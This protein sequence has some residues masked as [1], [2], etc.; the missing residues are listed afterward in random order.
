MQLTN[1]QGCT[2]PTGRESRLPSSTGSLNDQIGCRKILLMCCQYK[3]IK[4]LEYLKAKW[5]Q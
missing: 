5:K 1:P 3:K 4:I 2:S